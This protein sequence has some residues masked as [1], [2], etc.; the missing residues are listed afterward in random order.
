MVVGQRPDLN[1]KWTPLVEPRNV[2]QKLINEV[3]RRTWRTTELI[4]RYFGRWPQTKII[5]TS[6]GKIFNNLV[7]FNANVEY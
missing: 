1:Q 7:Q 2:P 5:P 6:M 3:S 4:A